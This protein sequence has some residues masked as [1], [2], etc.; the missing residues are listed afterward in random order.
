MKITAFLCTI[1][2]IASLGAGQSLAQSY[3]SKPIRV[4]VAIAIG[5][6]TD[7]VLRAAGQELFGSLGQPLVI[8]NR[9]GGN[10]MIAPEACARASADGYTLCVVSNATMSLNPHV[11]SKLPY[12][13][14]RDFAPVTA[15]WYLIQG[16]VATPSLSANSVR[17]LQVLATAKSGT[18]NF[19]TLGDGTGG[20][21]L[22]QWLNETWKA[23]IAGIPYKGANL[24][25]SALMGGE[26]QLSRIS[27]SGLS[28][29]VK[30]G[31][32]KILALGAS[33]RSRLFPEAPTY[34]EAGLG[35]FPDEKVWWGL[36]APAATPEAI[37]RRINVEFVRLFREPKF[38]EYLDNQLLE[39]A[40]S[41]PE[42]FAAFVKEDRER[43]GLTVKKYNIP[44]Q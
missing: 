10:M 34:A 1:L 25:T 38:G 41:T 15:L 16:L 12:N 23:N 4:I 19:G 8:D 44:R 18:L 2:A 3:P 36:F 32:L 27:L 28:G 20:D 31:K 39:P 33:K 29:Q 42:D 17:E 26:I 13:P 5:S 37:V 43:A 9:P 22:R 40:V 21:I 14:D 11:F 35:S 30:A 7:V 6:P 24:I